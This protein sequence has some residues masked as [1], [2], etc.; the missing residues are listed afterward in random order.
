MTSTSRGLLSLRVTL[1]KWHLRT[2]SPSYLCPST[3]KSSSS[4]TCMHSSLLCPSPHLL[5]TALKPT[6]PCR[7]I[8]L[9]L[10]NR[11]GEKQVRHGQRRRR[12]QTGRLW[13]Q[14][15]VPP[16]CCTVAGCWQATQD[17]GELLDSG[18]GSGNESYCCLTH[19][20]SLSLRSLSWNVSPA[21][22]V[23]A[24]AVLTGCQSTHTQTSERGQRGYAGIYTVVIHNI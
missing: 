4:P 8:T 15:L 9:R 16:C 5:S 13:L 21:C 11:E 3:P 6:T 18:L 22:H 2:S 19:W 7:E 1:L 10:I 12:T 20:W 14:H 23:C 17:Q 24:L